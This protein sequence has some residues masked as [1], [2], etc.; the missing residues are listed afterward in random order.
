MTCLSATDDL[1]EVWA[2]RVG[3]VRFCSGRE[4]SDYEAQAIVKRQMG[5]SD[6][7]AALLASS[8]K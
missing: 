2:E 7:D 1:L 6:E 8:E 4:M 5:L 3:I